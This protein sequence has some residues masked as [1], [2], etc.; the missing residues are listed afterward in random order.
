MRPTK[1][2]KTRRLLETSSRRSRRSVA[3]CSTRR[4]STWPGVSTD[5]TRTLQRTAWFLRV[6]WHSS[7]WKM[8]M[9]HTLGVSSTAPCPQGSASSRLTSCPEERR[10]WLPLLSC[11]PSTGEQR[12]CW[13]PLTCSYHPA[14]FFVLDEVD[15][16][17][18]ATN[19]AKLARFVREQAG[20]KN[21]D[22]S[23][24]HKSVQ[25]LIISLKSTL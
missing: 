22:P 3:S 6:V 13:A 5:T 14:P 1:H 4:S 18:D 9:S 20:G 2:G 16:A 8:L 7:T 15:A 24:G 12:E 11:S 17:L 25:F 10:P 21:S 23:D 19:V